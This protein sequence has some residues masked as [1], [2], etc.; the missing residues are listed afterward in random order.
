MTMALGAGA[1]A[2]VGLA[3]M[4]IVRK[5]RRQRELEQAIN[6]TQVGT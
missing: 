5:R 2:L 6:E 3:A 4:M 1:V